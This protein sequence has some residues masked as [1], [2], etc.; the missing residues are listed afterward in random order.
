MDLRGIHT[1]IT[2]MNPIMAVGNQP[3]LLPGCMLDIEM[4]DREKNQLDRSGYYIDG[5]GAGTTAGIQDGVIGA[6]RSFD[7]VDDYLSLGTTANLGISTFSIEFWVKPTSLPAVNAIAGRYISSSNGWYVYTDTTGKVNF[8]WYYGSSGVFNNSGS[9]LLTTTAWA[10]V[11]ITFTSTTST[12][13]AIY[14][15]G[16]LANSGTSANVIVTSAMRNMYIGALQGTADFFSGL[17]GLFR[18]YNRVL[19]AEDILSLYRTSAGR[20]GLNR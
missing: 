5:S 8:V 3:A 10:H 15:N 1:I 17:I 9:V 14:V 7:G 19:T 20:Y 11:V 13:W 12:V 16:V 6:V 2:P 18:M 4:V